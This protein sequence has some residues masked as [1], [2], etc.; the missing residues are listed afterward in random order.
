M[1]SNQH[2]YNYF[3]QNQQF[4]PHPPIY[5]INRLPREDFHPHY[6]EDIRE[7]Y[8][9]D[10][11]KL[12][13]HHK[14]RSSSSHRR[15]NSFSTSRSHF[16]E[17]DPNDISIYEESYYY[18]QQK[19]GY[20]RFSGVRSVSPY[21][22]RE[23]DIIASERRVTLDPTNASWVYP[24]ND[25]FV[26]YMP[27]HPMTATSKPNYY[28]GMPYRSNGLGVG[29][30]SN[31]HFLPMT[32]NALVP[33]LHQ[34]NNYN[35]E[36]L[37]M[38]Q[39]AVPMIS[40][41]HLVSGNNNFIYPQPYQY[42][43]KQFAV[44]ANA[45]NFIHNTNAQ[46]LNR[47]LID[48]KSSNCVT[49]ENGSA[50]ETH[51]LESGNQ[52]PQSTQ[53]EPNAVIRSNENTCMMFTNDYSARPKVT[54]KRRKSLMEGILSSFSL[55]QEP[56]RFPVASDDINLAQDQQITHNM[57]ASTFQ[58]TRNN[59]QISNSSDAE[60]KSAAL[61]ANDSQISTD[62]DQKFFR[63]Y[64]ST[65]RHSSSLKLNQKASLLKSREYIWCYRLKEEGTGNEE[66]VHPLAKSEN[67]RAW[68]SFDIRNQSIL[69]SHYT[70]IV[71]KKINRQNGKLDNS[72]NNNDSSLPI[73][74]DPSSIFVLN[75]QT[76][77]PSSVV[78]SIQDG[79]AWYKS[80]P[81][82]NLSDDL[83]P[84]ENNKGDFTFL[85]LAYMPTRLN[86]LVFTEDSLKEAE[87]NPPSSK[88][89]SSLRRSKSLDRVKNKLFKTI[90]QW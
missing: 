56:E 19:Q 37:L 63:D 81:N 21:E 71:A 12:A 65:R 88:A 46:N 79:I 75:K 78:V 32:T 10:D 53:G 57:E 11:E 68:S 6:H 4:I 52:L 8:H 77:I 50:E 89:N 13:R 55:L 69:D 42:Y 38:P 27:Q 73:I 5:H 60:K 70:F 1:Q 80:N 54:I 82:S 51:K 16:H 86:T 59:S 7:A 83:L 76:N 17:E 47:D 44:P 61:T 62:T 84:G 74:T 72:K 28:R 14:K 18:P 85:E 40:P 15:R 49:G 26:N 22:Q 34:L 41:L 36:L 31:N 67:K 45:G 87:S 66:S 2:Y 25:A 43:N 48:A 29:I 35:N 20:R 30:T 24:P 33:P 90:L 39:P 23:D 3:H 64:A 58:E 9:L